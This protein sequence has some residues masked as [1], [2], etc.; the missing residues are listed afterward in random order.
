MKDSCEVNGGQ[1]LT[2]VLFAVAVASLV[3]LGLTRASI[4]ALRNAQF[5]KNQ[6]LATQYAQKGMEEVRQ[7]RDQNPEEFWAKAAT[8]NSTTET[9]PLTGVFTQ[10]ITFYHQFENKMVV[11]VV[12]W[13]EDAQGRH[14]SRLVSYLTKWSD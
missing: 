9:T 2:E 11:T 13:W 3:L 6:S 12:V 5:A 10:E 8:G 14:E 7:M 1:T 4:S